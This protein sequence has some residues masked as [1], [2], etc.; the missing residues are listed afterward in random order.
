[1]SAAPVSVALSRAGAYGWA[2]SLEGVQAVSD[3][4]RADVAV[5]DLPAQVGASGADSGTRRYLIWDTVQVAL[6]APLHMTSV[7]AAD[8]QPLPA[9]LEGLADRCASGL[10]FVG[11]TLFVFVD[12]AC[13][14]RAQ[15]HAGGQG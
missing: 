4:P 11:P 14:M 10:V 6:L 9:L 2:V 15:D 7:A 1:L 3:Q 12:R 13:L 8:I 5:V